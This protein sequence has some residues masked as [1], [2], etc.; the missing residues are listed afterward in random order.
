[1]KVLHMKGL[2]IVV[3]LGSSRKLWCNADCNAG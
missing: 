1:M 2:Y 3:Y